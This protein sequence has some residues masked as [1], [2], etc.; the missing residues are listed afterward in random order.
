MWYIHVVCI[1]NLHIFLKK[2]KKH[3]FIPS[4][5][6]GSGVSRFTITFFHKILSFRKYTQKGANFTNGVRS[7]EHLPPS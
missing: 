1:K 2:K 4:S 6:H 3:Y 5:M 7:T